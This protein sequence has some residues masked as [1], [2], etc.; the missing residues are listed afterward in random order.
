MRE[1]IITRGLP[2]SGRQRWITHNLQ[3]PFIEH[4][5]QSFL[6]R[7]A[8][9]S[10][11]NRPLVAFGQHCNLWEM[12]P[13]VY[14]TRCYGIPCRVVTCLR[15]PDGR[16]EEALAEQLRYAVLPEEW[17]VEEVVNYKDTQ[18]WFKSA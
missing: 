14:I 7:L 6:A 18:T 3:S 4:N 8:A 13:Y 9:T 10:G 15:K 2:H 11:T 12:S 17:G 16:A 1:V 5:F